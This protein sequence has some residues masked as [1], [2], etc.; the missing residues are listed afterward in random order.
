MG[1]YCENNGLFMNLMQFVLGKGTTDK[2]RKQKSYMEK[3]VVQKSTGN[4]PSNFHIRLTDG[5]NFQERF[6]SNFGSSI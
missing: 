4:K 1:D 2:Q 6:L 3:K 5:D